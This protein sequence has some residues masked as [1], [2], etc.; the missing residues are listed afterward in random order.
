MEKNKILLGVL[1][2]MILLPLLGCSNDGGKSV[3][4]SKEP[5]DVFVSAK[6]D[7]YQSIEELENAS[8]LIVIGAK[9]N[10]L[11]SDVVYDKNGVYQI[12][13][14]YSSFRIDEIVSNK[15][16]ESKKEI[17]IFENQAYDKKYNEILHIAGYTNMVEGNKYI[18][19][20]RLA[21]EGYYIPLAVTIGKVPLTNS[22]INGNKLKMKNS[23]NE[24]DEII[25]KLHKEIQ[26]KYESKID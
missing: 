16:E 14:T 3:T 23:D 4:Y 5:E 21:D 26:K 1:A 8:D 19:Y 17:T 13:Y 22:E 12:A 11:K 10:E 9:V 18:L 15:V 6:T 25:E 7:S 20:L 24:S 2:L